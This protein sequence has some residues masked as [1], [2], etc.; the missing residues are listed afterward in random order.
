MKQQ[1]ILL[2]SMSACVDAEEDMTVVIEGNNDESRKKWERYHLIGD[3]LRHNLPD[4]QPTNLADK[5][6]AALQT[7]AIVFAPNQS[8]MNKHKTEA[9]WHKNPLRIAA[10]VAVLGVAL[11]VGTS[12]FETPISQVRTVLAPSNFS[13]HT[14]MKNGHKIERLAVTT[15]HRLKMNPYLTQHG[16]AALTQGDVAFP[17]HAQVVNYPEQ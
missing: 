17:L 11:L 14:V 5:I 15:P 6:Q 1:N 2:E 4:Y 3:A 9:W 10:S 8:G 12:L 7:E 16:A 13:T